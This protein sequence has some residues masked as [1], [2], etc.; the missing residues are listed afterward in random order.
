MLFGHQDHY[1]LAL[2]HLYDMQCYLHIVALFS[3]ANSP[4]IT[5]SLIQHSYEVLQLE[6]A[7]P[8]E[9][10]LYNYN[11]WCSLVTPMWLTHTWKYISENNL[12]VYSDIPPLPVLC[13][14]DEF[15]M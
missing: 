4:L 10:L 8:N 13:K 2:P 15:I 3:Y 7:L 9:I 14:K 6:L 5:G 11:D 1:G 12:K